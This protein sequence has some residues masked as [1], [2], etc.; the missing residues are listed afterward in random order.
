MLVR[1]KKSAFTL[2]EL[3]VVIT[4]IGVLIALLLPGVQSAREAAR[5]V[6]CKSHLKQ[7][8]IALLAF[9]DSQGEFPQGGWGR[10]WV[11]VPQRGLGA[12]QPGGW[13]YRTLPFLEEQNLFDSIDSTQ[14]LAADETPIA[15]VDLTSPIFNCP[16][17]RAA[18]SRVVGS[19][20]PHQKSPRPN[21]ELSVVA[22]GD[23]AINSGTSHVFRFT[24]PT[25]LILGDDPS[26]WRGVTDNRSFTGVSHMH[27]SVR[28]KQIIDGLSQTY[29]VGE[30][31]LAPSHYESGESIGDDETVY[32]GF[33]NDN[34]RYAASRPDGPGGDDESGIL[35]YPPA[36]DTDASLSPA[37]HT[38]FGSVHPAGFHMLHSDGSVR[39]LNY[40]IDPVSH[41]F[42]ANR[43]DEG[44]LRR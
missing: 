36:K 34:H 44:Q 12:S 42:G 5:R 38:R 21:G 25:T 24:G 1:S 41:Y 2:I 23:Y 15:R 39:L 22:R 31:F 32:S 13:V 20:S 10:A 14:S 7:M 26:F 16:S 33:A 9:H 18:L 19:R 30:K 27:R 28:L 11:P 17:R 29:L 40:D 43:S 6:T 37:G 8:G 3:L 35:F 4:I